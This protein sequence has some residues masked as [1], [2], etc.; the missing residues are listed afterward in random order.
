[1]LWGS[2][3]LTYWMVPLPGGTPG[4]HAAQSGAG[5]CSRPRVAPPGSRRIGRDGR[6]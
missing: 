2:T 6:E 5:S 1:M 4:L 3:G